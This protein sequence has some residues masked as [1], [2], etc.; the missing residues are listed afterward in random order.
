MNEGAGQGRMGQHIVE[1]YNKE[2]SYY[3][4]IS[5]KKTKNGTV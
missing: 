1:W 5:E 2:I 3:V 4:I